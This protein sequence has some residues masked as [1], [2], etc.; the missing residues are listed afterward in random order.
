MIVNNENCMD[1]VLKA[2]TEFLAQSYTIKVF[3]KPVS[4]IIS[5]TIKHKI[6]NVNV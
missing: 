5:K 3:L 4:H 2:D 6:Y 1:D